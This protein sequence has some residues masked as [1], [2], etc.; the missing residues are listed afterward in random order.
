MIFPGDGYPAPDG[1]ED[2]ESLFSLL[3]ISANDHIRGLLGFVLPLG[4]WFTSG[5]V[6]IV[7]R[8]WAGKCEGCKRGCPGMGL[9]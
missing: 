1:G 5:G 2:S 4:V 9:S 7:D 3:A 8:K 6:P